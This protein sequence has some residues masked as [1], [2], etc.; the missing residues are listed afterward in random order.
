MSD[1]EKLKFIDGA[2]TMG[3]TV[4]AP[5]YLDTSFER[6]QR[7]VEPLKL[8]SNQELADL[9]NLDYNFEN[10][11]KDYDAVAQANV[12]YTNWLSDLNKNVGE[13]DNVTNR[14]SYLDA[15]RNNKNQAV[16]N[17][18]T[19]GARAAGELLANREA[20]QNK[21][22]ANAKSATNRFQTENEALLRIRS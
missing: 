1:D 6:Y 15:I 21:V 5:A 12:D 19:T 10:I 8:Y 9:Y 14:T 7:E 20:I 2:S 18:M 13:R 3:V 22:N 17:G 16:I 4:P 11:K